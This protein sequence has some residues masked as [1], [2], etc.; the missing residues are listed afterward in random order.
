VLVE[1]LVLDG[2]EGLGDL[3]GQ[4]GEG[5]DRTLRLGEVGE[6][7]AVTVEEQRRAAGLERREPPHV[8]T[9]GK[10]AMRPGEAEEQHDRPEHGQEPRQRARPLLLEVSPERAP[11]VRDLHG[12]PDEEQGA[13]QGLDGGAGSGPPEEV[14]VNHPL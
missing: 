14:R 6:H 5:D 7:L 2:E 4:G 8:R 13:C 3:A 12:G 9:G 11:A 1:A 10:K